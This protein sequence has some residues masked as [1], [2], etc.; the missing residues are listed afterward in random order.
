MYLIKKQLPQEVRV[1]QLF[2]FLVLAFFILINSFNCTAKDAV[3]NYKPS[4]DFSRDTAN[5]SLAKY[6]RNG[7]Y[8]INDTIDL[9]RRTLYI[10][11]NSTLSV[12]G[13][14]IRNGIINGDNTKLKYKKGCAV[15]DSV[16]ITGTWIVGSIRSSMFKDL[17]YENSLKDVFAL[18]NPIIHNTVV[19]EKG[20]YQVTANKPKDVC[21]QI[22]SNTDVILDGD[23]YLTPNGYVMYSIVRL[24]GDN[25]TLKGT[26]SIN[27]DKYTHTSRE[28][29][30]GM[31][32]FVMGGNNNRI[33]GVTVKDCW[34]DCIYIT[35]NADGLVID[36][37]NLSDGRRQGISVISVRNVLIK[38][39]TISKVR[40]T[41]PGYAID[42]ETNK[43]DTVLAVT[44]KNLKIFDCFGGIL[45]TDGMAQDAYIDEVIVRNCTIRDIDT[46]P[47]KFKRTN[48]VVVRNCDIEVPDNKEGM[49]C[50]GV[51]NLYL[52]RSLIN[53]Q[54]IKKDIKQNTFITIDGSNKIV[55]H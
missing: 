52:E 55:I 1:V 17:S 29:E 18:T 23:I 33:I 22:E 11:A 50:Y 14:V 47:F 54:R 37:C 49:F 27:G 35:N 32:I 34:G 41:P 46:Y 5:V 6:Y 24:E 26:G 39:C 19:I 20:V 42:V 30:W 40:G 45:T 4:I 3:M 36:K 2:G 15:F 13:G 48:K 8:V 21:V 10:P 43:G 53:G 38:N 28:G 12:R 31:G 7:T 44:I 9:N 51:K 25:I 16:N